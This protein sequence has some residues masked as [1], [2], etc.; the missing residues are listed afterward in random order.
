MPFPEITYP[1]SSLLPPRRTLNQPQPHITCPRPEPP[2]PAPTEQSHGP[3]YCN[4]LCHWNQALPRFLPRFQVDT[5]PR[6]KRNY[7]TICNPP[8]PDPELQDHSGL[9]GSESHSCTTPWGTRAPLPVTQCCD[10]PSGVSNAS[11]SP[12]TS[13]PHDCR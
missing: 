10:L 13:S 3:I 6:H 11:R 2:S 8:Q 7:H 12:S 4:H 9:C 1:S 5:G